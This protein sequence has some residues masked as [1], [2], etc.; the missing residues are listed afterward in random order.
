MGAQKKEVC[1]FPGVP[2]CAAKKLSHVPR[3]SVL[4]VWFFSLLP[5]LEV[6]DAVAMHT[7]THT[8]TCAR[9]AAKTNRLTSS[10]LNVPSVSLYLSIVTGREVFIYGVLV[11]A[12]RRGKT[13][14]KG[15][16]CGIYFLFF[17]FSS[18]FFSSVENSTGFCLPRFRRKLVAV[19]C[20]WDLVN[21]FLRQKNSTAFL[22]ELINPPPVHHTHTNT[23]QRHR[24]T[25]ILG[26]F[27][28]FSLFPSLS[29]CLICS[30]T[31]Q[32]IGRYTV[33]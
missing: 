1:T 15:K 3:G 8:R 20:M 33:G 27:C 21:V 19:G 13:G 29:V 12:S 22:A 14:T 2:C 7:H 16:V 11:P 31:H 23:Q 18:I 26:T 5:L 28:V 6:S 17:H 32:P 24:V 4:G 10:S 25:R 30:R 9:E